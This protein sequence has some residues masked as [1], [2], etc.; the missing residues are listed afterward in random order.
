MVANI[1]ILLMIPLIITYFGYTVYT[2]FCWSRLKEKLE[3]TLVSYHNVPACVLYVYSN[4]KALIHIESQE[5]VVSVKDLKPFE[6]KII[7]F[8]TKK[9]E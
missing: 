5:Y 4:G 9:A 8:S 7:P 1:V 3:G 2:V 6:A